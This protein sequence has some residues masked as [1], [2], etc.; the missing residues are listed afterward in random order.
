[1]LRV[2]NKLKI[3][4]VADSGEEGVRF[5]RVS[6]NHSLLHNFLDPYTPPSPLLEGLLCGRLFLGISFPTI[7]E[8]SASGPSEL[9]TANCQDFPAGFLGKLSP[10]P[11]PDWVWGWCSLGGAGCHQR[12]GPL[13]WSCSYAC[14][15]QESHPD[16]SLLGTLGPG[17]SQCLCPDNLLEG[18]R[19]DLEQFSLL[20]LNTWHFPSWLQV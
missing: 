14:L 3:Y 4:L 11:T 12:L 6:E 19:G 9:T 18:R 8:I 13:S 10:L 16:S 1:M 15:A 20:R 7:L 5:C 17:S 2:R